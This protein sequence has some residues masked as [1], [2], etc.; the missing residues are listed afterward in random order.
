MDDVNYCPPCFKVPKYM[1]N[2]DNI[3]LVNKVVSRTVNTDDDVISEFNTKINRNDKD[4]HTV[5]SDS[6]GLVF[7]TL[8]KINKS[9]DSCGDDNDKSPQLIEVYN[10]TTFTD[11]CE[12]KI[13]YW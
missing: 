5:M 10:P 6:C 13:E 8:N 1:S 3:R 11:V 7:N 2:D 12:K 9:D 4:A